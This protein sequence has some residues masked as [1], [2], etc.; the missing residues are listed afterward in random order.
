MTQAGAASTRCIGL[1]CRSHRGP[2]PK[3]TVNRV[4]QEPGRS[5]VSRVFLNRRRGRRTTR[6]QAPRQGVGKRSREELSPEYVRA[7]TEEILDVVPLQPLVRRLP[8][9]GIAALMCV[10]ASAAACHRSLVAARL[11]RDYG[12]SVLDIVAA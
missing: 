3:R 5:A 8:V 1:A 10:E 6:P 2:R 12:A 9:H 11:A 7:Y 4:L